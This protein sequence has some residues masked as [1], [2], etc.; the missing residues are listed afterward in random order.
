MEI[1]HN[2]GDLD[3]NSDQ[4]EKF[5]AL[6]EHKTLTEAA[7]SLFI[8]Q[9]A[10]SQSLTKLEEELQCKLFTR[11]KGRLIINEN[12][13]KLLRH[14]NSIL[15]SINKA[16]EELQQPQKIKLVST[17]IC[18]AFMLKSLS[19]NQLC[20][21]K[22]IDIEDSLIPKMLFTDEIDMAACDDYYLHN[23]T[24]PNLNRYLLCVEYLALLVPEGHELYERKSLTYKDINGISLCI[25]TDVTSQYHWI[26]RL[27]EQHPEI[28]FNID[29][30]MERYTFGYIRDK[31]PYPEILST[32]S[33]VD[34][35]PPISNI[36]YKYIRII[37]EDSKRNLYLWY[38][39]KN[40][41]KA[42]FLKSSV[43]EFYKDR[44]LFFLPDHS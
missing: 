27:Q 5:K 29:F 6:C 9:S 22:L 12:G 41:S 13:L 20:N 43:K 42:E 10:L 24:N 39:T 21:I 35:A 17:N 15:A 18:A 28:D 36:K 8:S 7:N 1:L 34:L 19:T 30:M 32:N 26:Q 40:R 23:S 31:I 16:V 4:L 2:E 38:L 44:D 14:T 37:E 33:I 11:T 3:L 25:R